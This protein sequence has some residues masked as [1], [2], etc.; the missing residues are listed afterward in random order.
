MGSAREYAVG[1][2]PKCRAPVW[3]AMKLPSMMLRNGEVSCP[4]T[5]FT[6]WPKLW[7]SRQQEL[8]AHDLQK[9]LQP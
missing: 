5:A 7:K 1:G 9:R 2:N 3:S 8:A 4:P 6:A